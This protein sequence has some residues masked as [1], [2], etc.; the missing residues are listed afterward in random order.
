MDGNFVTNIYYPILDT[1]S[2][3]LAAR[4]R[5]YEELNVNINFFYNLSEIYINELKIQANK[6]VHKYPNDLEDALE[7]ENTIN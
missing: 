1:L 7:N 4:K 2:V 6:L 3:Q 5:V